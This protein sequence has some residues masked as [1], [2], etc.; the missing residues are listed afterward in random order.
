[1]NIPRIETPTGITVFFQGETHTKS[2]SA[3]DF[4]EFVAAVE[5]GDEQTLIRTLGIKSL[6]KAYTGN[7]FEVKDGTVIDS[8]TA[9]EV[10][11][12]LRQRIVD[13]FKA[14]KS[15][16]YLLNF[17][18]RLR[19]NPSQ[20]AINDLYS[21][22]ESGNIPITPEGFILAYRKVDS[23]YTSFH[24]NPDG[25]KNRNM[26]GDVVTMPRE[27]VTADRNVTCS[28]GLLLLFHL[29]QYHTVRGGL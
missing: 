14:G 25:T 15:F 7:K 6:L 11:P 8:E 19:Q 28:S 20:S 23:D 9:T 18:T 21:F 12:A 29:S 3:P 24:A 27:E 2:K 4:A 1:M 10:H 26:V 5:S 16:D 22:L 17:L 13:L